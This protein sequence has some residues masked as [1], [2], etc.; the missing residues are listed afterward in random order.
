EKKALKAVKKGMFFIALLLPLYPSFF[1]SFAEMTNA[2][3]E[4]F[5]LSPGAKARVLRRGV[6][7]VVKYLRKLPS[8]PAASTKEAPLPQG[9]VILAADISPM[10]VISHLPVLCEDHSVPYVFVKS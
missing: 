4:F 6:K 10:D 5:S 2:N 1:L 9:F 8:T 7:E 3:E